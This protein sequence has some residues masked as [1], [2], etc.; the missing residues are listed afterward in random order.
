[1]NV[2]SVEMV[3]A[4][5]KTGAPGPVQSMGTNIT[6]TGA[7]AEGE[8]LMVDFEFTV[9]YQPSQSRILLGG[10]AVFRD[11]GSVKS[12]AEWS[13][14]GRISG[15]AGE[16]ILNA[17]NYSAVVNGVLISRVFN[18]PPPLMLPR[19]EFPQES[20]GTKAVPSRGAAQKGSTPRKK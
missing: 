9:T 6:L 4:D 12:A 2:E 20:A 10:R 13:S 8:R 18:L 19:L 7:R 11:E 15:P 16:F 5:V 17:I 1:M 3:S 14:T